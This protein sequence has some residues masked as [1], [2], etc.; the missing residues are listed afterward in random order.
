[1][2]RPARPKGPPEALRAGAPRRARVWHTP[3]L[4][5]VLWSFTRATPWLPQVRS[6]RTD[7]RVMHRIVRDGW[8]RHIRDRRGV[9]AFIARQG[10]VIHALY[11]HPRARRR[12]LG[13]RLLEEAKRESDRLI[14]WT[15]EA[16]AAARAFYTAQGF[17][18]AGRGMGEG[19]DEALPDI[20]MVWTKEAQE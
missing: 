16:N 20:K 4:T 1:M 15:L 5:R 14:L 17:T 3:A 18:E 8:V 2:T 11:V 10:E 13:G 6:R 7:L 9:V 19:N 12:G